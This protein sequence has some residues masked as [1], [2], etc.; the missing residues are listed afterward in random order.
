MLSLSAV[1]QPSELL[2][3]VLLT[4]ADLKSYRFTYWLGVPAIIPESTAFTSTPV[5]LLK[6]QHDESGC[7]VSIE[8]YRALLQKLAAHQEDSEPETALQPVFALRFPS[9]EDTQHSSIAGETTE[10][11]MQH[12]H[13]AELLSFADA[14][15]GRHAPGLYIVVAD[16]SAATTGFG[17]IVRNLLA[18]LAIHQPT[19]TEGPSMCR[20]I[21]LRGSTAVKL[22]G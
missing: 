20:I 18:M 3:F 21:G 9:C 17:W 12:I 19:D 4:F 6:E 8:L 14:W 16:P 2:S 1:S 13:H 5:Q 22:F 7:N 15:S 11:Q 10:F